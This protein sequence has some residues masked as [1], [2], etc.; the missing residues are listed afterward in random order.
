MDRAGDDP[1]PGAVLRGTRPRPPCAHLEA[2]A[3]E[4]GVAR[5]LRELR[6]GICAEVV[7]P[8]TVAVGDGIEVLEADPRSEGRRIAERLRGSHWE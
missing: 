3:G 8:G 1:G 6:G 7:D 4:E 2:V 5:A